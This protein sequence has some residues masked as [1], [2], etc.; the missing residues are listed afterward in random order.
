MNFDSRKNLDDAL[1]ATLK[2]I[3]RIFNVRS[4]V[5]WTGNGYHIYLPIKAFILEEEEVF[6]K[7]QNIGSNEP[8]LSLS[9]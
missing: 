5:L 3:Y 6:A 9:S 4:T 8:S 2:R 1:K 7:F